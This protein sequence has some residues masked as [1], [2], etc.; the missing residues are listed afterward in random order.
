MKLRL[1]LLLLLPAALLTAQADSVSMPKPFDPASKR[2]KN[3]KVPDP[4]PF[5]ESIT[6]ADIKTLVDS[7]ASP[8]MEGRETG[9]PGQR[10]AA[11]FIAAQF[12][13]L[14]LPTVG[15]RNTYFQKIL[16]QNEGWKEVSV[17]I[18]EQELQSRKDYLVFPLY[19]PD[20]PLTQLKEVVFVGY[21]IE[22]KSYNDYAKA[23]VSGKAVIFYDGEPMNDKGESLVTGSN[24]RSNW[25]MDWQ[26]KV[27][28]AK[29]KGATMAF[30]I[31][32]SIEDL[33]S[34]KRNLLSA[35]GW[36]PVATDSNQIEKD[37]INNIF[38]SQEAA[39][40]ILGKKSGK[41]ADA[42]ADLREKG[43]F[44][45]V[46]V[47][48]KMEV[49]LDKEG[50]RLEGSNVI[51]FIEGADPVLKKE[52][53]FITAHYDHLGKVDDVIYYG[54]DDN[55]SGTA[56]V[57]EIAR[58]FTEAKEKG[59][60]PARTVVCMLVSGEEKGLLGSKFYTEFPM[61]PLENTVVD[62]NID[63]VG[64]IDDAHAGNPNYIYVIGSDRLSSDLHRI[65]EEVNTEY[66]RLELNY[67]YNAL[68]DPNHYY[69]R[70]DHYNFAEKGIP[71]IF[72]FNGTHADYHRPTDTA[73]KI[74][75]AAAARRAQLAFYT[76]WDIA[77]RPWK[78]T[79]DKVPAKF[80]PRQG[81]GKKK[82]Q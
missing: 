44:K 33:A 16:L 70:S 57:I 69:E 59:F 52:Y 14:K 41:T 66:T 50:R 63:M 77:N 3:Y 54:A 35:Y 49:R 61:F 43:T 62:I 34:A 26:R 24:F 73:E 55:A 27:K 29:A 8:A 23:D 12:K 56:S 28:L 1:I 58:A 6:A 11:D 45:P 78:L 5:A 2:F 21:G 38:L 32:P 40:K 74:D 64:R 17:R 53:V 79:V 75:S 19:N 76:A 60:G 25:A 48:T 80:K 71:A 46:K 36:Q 37:F 51:A 81:Q 39:D 7:L 68:N 13:A 22:D 18:G 30:I 42:L 72:Y 47:K 20:R 82:K 31:V 4:K 10:R 65:N 67:K 9:E 15:D